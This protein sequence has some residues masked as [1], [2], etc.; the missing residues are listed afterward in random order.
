MDWFFLNI[1]ILILIGSKK[2]TVRRLNQ[3]FRLNQKT[4]TGSE[5]NNAPKCEKFAR[6]CIVTKVTK[7][8]QSVN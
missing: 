4:R 1:L 3:Y 8:S 5:D 6:F 7:T 2:Q